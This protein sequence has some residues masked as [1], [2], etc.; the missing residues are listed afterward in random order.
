[1]PV[2]KLTSRHERGLLRARHFNLNRV[3]RRGANG[4]GGGSQAHFCEHYPPREFHD[5]LR[6]TNLSG[7]PIV[8]SGTPVRRSGKRQNTSF[9]CTHMLRIPV[10]VKSR[11]KKRPAGVPFTLIWGTWTNCG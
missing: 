7:G 6:N 8:L 9:T 5:A 10:S 4:S 3:D 1:M 2:W 11:F